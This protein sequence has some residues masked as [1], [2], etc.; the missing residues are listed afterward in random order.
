MWG[1]RVRF[2]R[3]RPRAGRVGDRSCP[4][5][6]SGSLRIRRWPWPV[7]GRRASGLASSS[8]VCSSSTTLATPSSVGSSNMVSISDCS[9][10]ERRP[11]APVLRAS[12]L[13]AIAASADGRISSSTPSMREELLVL[14]DQRV[15]RL[16]EDLHQ[17][18]FGQLAQRGDDR[19]AAD[20]FGDQ[21][22]LDQVFG[23][24]LAED[25]GDAL[26][27]SC[28]APWRRSRCPTSR[29]GSGSPSPG[30][31]RRRRR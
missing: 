4:I 23:L 2:A 18:V 12:A 22:E 28:C 26:F 31:R 8:M 13:R 14:L 3:G 21:A 30:R 16:G 11:R 15:L 6:E 20:Q 7:R 29:C 1:S 27:A 10:I 19:Q 17:R 9:M 25:L 24:D 5:G